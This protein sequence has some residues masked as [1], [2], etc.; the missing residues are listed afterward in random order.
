MTRLISACEG[1]ARK[2]TGRAALAVDGLL[3]AP[4]RIHTTPKAL[5]VFIQSRTRSR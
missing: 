4:R 2:M 1:F 3:S 5:L